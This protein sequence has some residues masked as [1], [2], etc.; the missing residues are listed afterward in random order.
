LDFCLFFFLKRLKLSVTNK[1]SFFHFF[2]KNSFLNFFFKTLLNKKVRSFKSFLLLKNTKDLF[3][4]KNKFI[5]LQDQQKLKKKKF[6][7]KKKKILKVFLKQQN[8]SS[9]KKKKNKKKL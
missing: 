2:I 3:L 5:N 6:F 1:K 8:V 4:N 7:L 9:K